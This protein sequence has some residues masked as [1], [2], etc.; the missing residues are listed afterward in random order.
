EIREILREISLR[1]SNFS[2]EN[3]KENLFKNEIFPTEKAPVI[4]KDN[5]IIKI[6]NIKWGFEKWDNKGVIINAR[7]E[8]APYSSFFSKYINKNRCIV[9]AHGYFEW[10]NTNENKKIKFE[11][12][13]EK[14]NGIFMAGLFRKTKN[15]KEFVILTK[16][17]RE[18]IKQIHER[19]PLLLLKEQLLPWLEGYL[20]IDEIAN[21]Y[22]HKL[23]YE[24]AI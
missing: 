6:E 11:F 3:M 10:N 14:N 9:P 20:T 18:D 24:K 12:T 2:F 16:N 4:F 8:S 23:K 19:M 15:D 7:S 5:N 21:N 1:F 13:D 17:A 22:E